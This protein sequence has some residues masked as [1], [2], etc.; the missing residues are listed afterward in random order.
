MSVRGSKLDVMVIVRT[1]FSTAVKKIQ[2]FK[3]SNGCKDI[4]SIDLLK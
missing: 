2:L 1:N 4:A 3:E